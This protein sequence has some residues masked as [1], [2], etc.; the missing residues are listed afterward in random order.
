MRKLDLE[1]SETGV[2]IGGQNINNLRYTHDTTLLSETEEG[3][4]HLIN[5]VKEE[6]AKF[7]PFLKDVK[8]TKIMT[9]AGNGDIKIKIDNKEIEC[10]QEFTFLGSRIDQWRLQP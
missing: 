1:N 4:R 3:L 7:G 6:S 9:T 5:R 10:V 2:K 8:K